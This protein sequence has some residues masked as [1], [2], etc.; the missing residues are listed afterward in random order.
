MSNTIADRLQSQVQLYPDRPA[1]IARDRS[2][3]FAEL[4]RDSSRAAAYLQD[5]GLQ[6][7][8]RILVFLPIS[9]DLYITLIA[10]FKL[11]ITAM[12]VDPSAGRTHLEQCCTIA[13]PKALI[14][15]RKASLLLLRSPRLRQIRCKLVPGL[16]LPGLRNGNRWYTYQ[17]RDRLD[18]ATA[19]TPA[20]LTFTSGSTGR[21]KAALRTHQFL[22]VQHQVLARHL[23]LQPGAVDLT[24][25][26]IFI[27]ANL[28]S[29]VTS[30]IPD[31]DLRKPGFIDPA[32]IIRQIDTHQPAST[33]ASPAFLERLATYCEENNRSLHGLQRIFSGGAPVFPQ[34]CDRLQQLAPDAKIVTVYGS[35][36]AEPIAHHQFADTELGAVDPSKSPLKR[37]T[38]T[39]SLK[40]GGWGDRN[41][42]DSS[43]NDCNSLSNSLSLGGL[44]AGIPIPEIE[45]KII[46]DSWGTPIP[47]LTTEE[48]ASQ[49]LPPFTPGEIVVSG[50]HVLPGY[51]NGVGDS[52]TKFRVGN[53]PWHRTGDAGYFCDRGLLWLLGRCN[54]KIADSK[55]II[56]PF[57]VESIAHH[58]SSIKRAALV[59]HNNQ[60][61]L[62]LE[63]QPGESKHSTLIAGL[64]QAL[65]PAQLDRIKIVPNIPV[66]ARHNAKINYPALQKMLSQDE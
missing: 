15:T 19:E 50:A 8:D 60:R 66:D 3:S 55:G 23:E 4:D 38:S 39:A 7:G 11:G 56:Y 35:T 51:V 52:S 36:E 41:V 47:P 61:W 49:E 34:L 2:I 9:I 43:E 16:S 13:P 30:L 62:L 20:L 46:P 64:E 10:L 54:A 24:T 63:L 6:M 42:A 45:L 65:E 37:G 31:G 17:R 18:R 26:P 58:Y 48:F 14:A 44:C 33:A 1:I 29:G 40:K 21:P 59:S 5:L 12:F 25:L 53:T 22:L 28:A 32:P 27:L 57:A